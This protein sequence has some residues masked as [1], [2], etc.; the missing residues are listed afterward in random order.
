MDDHLHKPRTTNAVKYKASLRACCI[1]MI[2][3]SSSFLVM[4]CR[5]KNEDVVSFLKAHEH[6]VSAGDYSLAPGPSSLLPIR[7][8]KKTFLLLTPVACPKIRQSIE[9]RD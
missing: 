8:P 3:V 9:N 6:V 5:E 4:G 7:L 2:T 1:V